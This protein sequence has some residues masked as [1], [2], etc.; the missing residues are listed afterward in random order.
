[1]RAE[2]LAVG[3]EEL[4]LP[5][6][7]RTEAVEKLD[8]IYPISGRYLALSPQTKLAPTHEAAIFSY[9]RKYLSR[10]PNLQEWR[11][12]NLGAAFRSQRGSPSPLNIGERVCFLESYFLS[13]SAANYQKLTALCIE[14][15]DRILSRQLCLPHL[16][17]ERPLHGNLP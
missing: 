2:H 3:A 5:N 9:A 11:T 17:L 16:R 10:R 8:A 15:I 4:L 12:F 6:V 14:I 1:Y 13:K 7:L